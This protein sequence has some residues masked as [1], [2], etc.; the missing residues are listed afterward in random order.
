[1]FHFYNPCKGKKTFGFSD[2]FKGYMEY[3]FSIKELK[4]S[5]LFL[6]SVIFI[7]YHELLGEYNVF[8]YSENVL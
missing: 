7:Y 8:F 3:C 6:E 4:S 1:M 2:I 5:V